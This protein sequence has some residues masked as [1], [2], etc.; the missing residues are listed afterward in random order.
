MAAL[1]ICMIVKNEEDVIG[2]CLECVKDIADEIII[3]DTGSTDRTKEIVKS[4][5]DKIFDF[6]WINDFAAARNHSFALATEEYIMWLDADDVIDEENRR[7]LKALKDGL[8][9]PV[10]MVKMKYDVAFDAQGNPTVSYYRERIFRREMNYRWVGEIHEV[11]PPRGHIIHREIAIQHKKIRPN[12]PERN[13]K[14]FMKMISEG[15]AL[16]PRQKF[17]F[18]RELYYNA[19]YQEAI[20][21]FKDFLE[22][23]RGWLE[24]NISACKDLAACYYN[25]GNA[26]A[27]L[28]A[29][30]QS[31]VY[32]QPRAEIC[33]DIGRHFLDRNQCKNAVFWYETALTRPLDTQS[34][35]FIQPDCYGY[36]PYMQLCVCYDRLGDHQ[37]AAEC[38]DS[39]GKLKPEDEAYLY[40]KNY[41][42]NKIR[43]R[44]SGS[45]FERKNKRNRAD[46][47]ACEGA[48][49]CSLF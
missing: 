33:C 44:R 32:D 31:F 45:D 18:A 26:S 14:I 24:N 22:E 7:A 10:D 20:D 13:L 23:G 41:F 49:E 12:E 2:R 48:G 42:Q 17:Y 3:V 30:F 19:R 38:N 21:R 9:P 11:I 40:N 8:G 29:L 5:T 15:K 35:G 1:S 16:E 6:T 36:I 39:A 34:G 4:Y 28:A 27:A 46:A 43:A 47:R 37:K 25:I